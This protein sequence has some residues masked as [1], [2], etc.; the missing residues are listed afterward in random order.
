VAIVCQKCV[1]TDPAPRIVYTGLNYLRE[2]RMND[3]PRT[4]DEDTRVQ[5]CAHVKLTVA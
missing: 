3:L 1:L 5:R 4:L 2:W